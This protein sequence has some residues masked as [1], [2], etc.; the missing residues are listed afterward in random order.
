MNS[1]SLFFAKLTGAI[2]KGVVNYGK[3]IIKMFIRIWIRTFG[4]R[5]LEG[6]RI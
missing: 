4:L 1:G 3:R 2:M 6:D 5:N